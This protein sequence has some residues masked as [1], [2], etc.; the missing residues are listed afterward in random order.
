MKLKIFVALAISSFIFIAFGRSL[1]EV[2][3]LDKSTREDNLK[4]TDQKVL[5][6]ERIL[7]WYLI[8]VTSDQIITGN[9]LKMNRKRIEELEKRLKTYGITLTELIPA[10]SIID[11]A[12]EFGYFNHI[13]R[14][15]DNGSVK[16]AFD[17]LSGKDSE[18]KPLFDWTRFGCLIGIIIVTTG[19]FFLIR[20]EFGELIIGFASIMLC[21]ILI[22]GLIGL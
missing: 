6:V 11:S 9:E 7:R 21:I 17:Q 12:L 3:S 20:N 8:E 4:R 13:L 1:S 19:A 22:L 16:R 18:V 14:Y 15:R 5:N 2:N 10:V